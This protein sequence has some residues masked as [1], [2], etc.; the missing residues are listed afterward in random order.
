[1]DLD[2]RRG[3]RKRRRPRV[4][5][6]GRRRDEDQLALERAGARA[7]LHHV[8]RAHVRHRLR[9]ADEIDA[10]LTLVVD[11]QRLAAH[12]ELRFAW[13]AERQQ[14]A[15]LAEE[16][17]ERGDGERGRDGDRP[18]GARARVAHAHRERHATEPAVDVGQ[19]VHVAGVDRRARE[20]LNRAAEDRLR[21][22]GSCR[23]RPRVQLREERNRLGV[24]LPVEVVEELA[25]HDAARGADRRRERGIVRAS[26]WSK[27]ASNAIVRTS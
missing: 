7:L 23:R 18:G 16:V 3:A 1:M 8:E 11:R 13:G 19:E 12:D 26:A 22:G 9:R 15:A 14:R 6:D 27:T 4:E 17:P 5:A 21:A 10:E 24:R 25:E 20:H 2:A